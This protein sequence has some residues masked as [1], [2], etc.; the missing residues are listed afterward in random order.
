MK[1]KISKT[2]AVQEGQAVLFRIVRARRYVHGFLIRYQGEIFAY[3]NKCRHLPLSL[4][5]DDG[6]FFDEAR[7]HLVCQ[8]HGAIYEPDSGLCLR[9]P[10]QGARLFPIEFEELKGE[11]YVESEGESF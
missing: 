3:E 4:D 2:A 1:M 8:T 7:R 11:I 10:C 6:R 5:Y 9:G